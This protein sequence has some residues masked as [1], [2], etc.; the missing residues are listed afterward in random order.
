M[1]T[2]HLFKSSSILELSQIRVRLNM[3]SPPVI[4]TDRSNAVLLL[5]ILFVVSVSFTLVLITLSCLFLSA[6]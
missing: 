1:Q 4:F 5:W 6:L 2:K 3:L